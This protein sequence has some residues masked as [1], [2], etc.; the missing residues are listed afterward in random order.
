[1][2]VCADPK[3]LPFS[4]SEGKGFE[5]RIAEMLADDLGVPL[6][7]TW[8]RQTYI[9]RFIRSTLRRRLCDVVIGMP[10]RHEAVLNTN[11]LY[12]SVFSMVYRNDMENPPLSLAAT[13]MATLTVGV[14]AAEPPAWS[15]EKTGL[16]RE[17]VSYPVV[18]KYGLNES[19][20]LMIA[21]V[22]S[23][24]IDVALIWGAYAGYFG[25]MHDSLHVEPLFGDNKKYGR[26]IFQATMGVRANELQWKRRLNRFIRSK[27]Q[28]INSVL[29][30]YRV[31][32]VEE[33]GA[34]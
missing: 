29:E 1:M 7:Y 12:Y 2:R 13:R 28:E 15:L 34:Y 22:I 30:E 4:N 3:N 20:K 25:G 31:P 10:P 23:G 24:K 9:T 8:Y 21:D 16:Y 26:L 14:V 18:S 32:I 11:P 19:P 17:I 6:D 33:E 27:R 5:N